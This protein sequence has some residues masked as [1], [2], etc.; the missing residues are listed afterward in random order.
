MI[1]GMAGLPGMAGFPGMMPGMFSQLGGFGM[2]NMD[3][4]RAQA[5]L[6][7]A[8]MPSNPAAMLQM[9]QMQQM[10]GIFG[11]P[12]PA[13]AEKDDT[14][15]VK[16]PVLRLDARGQEIDE[17]GNVVDRGKGGPVSTLKVGASVLLSILCSSGCGRDTQAEPE[18]N[19]ASSIALFQSLLRK[20]T[21]LYSLQ[22]DCR[23][24]RCYRSSSF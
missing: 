3:P 23:L 11:Q 8:G 24:L 9:M 5:M 12:V 10:G 15:K 20:A 16:P 13:P 22:T 17:A 1:P 14:P 2:P 7:Q 18:L 6:M 4:F 19:E 21:Q